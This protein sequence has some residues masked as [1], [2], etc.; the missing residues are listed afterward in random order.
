MLTLEPDDAGRLSRLCGRFDD[1]LRQIEKHLGVKIRNR[2]NRFQLQG[3]P[4]TVATAQHILHHLYASADPDQQMTPEKLHL[5]LQ[6]LGAEPKT[7]KEQAA[8]PVLRTGHVTIKPRSS[9]QRAYVEAIQNGDLSFGIGPA[10]TGKTYLAVAC[11]VQDLEEHRVERILLTRPAVEAGERLGFLPGDLNQKVNPYLHPL[12]DALHE[13][14]GEQRLSKL[15]QKNL[16]EVVP[17]A[18]MRGRTLGNAFVILDEAQN[19]M[20]AQMKMFLTRLGFGSKAAVNGD[21]SQAD[22]PSGQCS[23]LSMARERLQGIE[24]IRFIHFD[25]GDVVRH[26]LVRRIVE[27]W[28]RPE[29]ADSR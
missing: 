10:G 27:A 21:P 13:M 26:A 20:P 14:L 28:D 15:M 2:G 11:A 1:N 6:D 5:E 17:L 23:G 18:Y 19:T 7:E 8:W 9:N 29:S 3:K 22:L 24:G 25:G 12:Y 4:Q 16:I